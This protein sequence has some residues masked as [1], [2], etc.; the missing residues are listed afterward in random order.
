MHKTKHHLCALSRLLVALMLAAVLSLLGAPRVAAQVVINEVDSD[1]PGTD[2]LEFVELYDGG[3]GNTSLDGLVVVFYN[4]SNDLSYASFDLDGFRTDA[5]GFFLMGNSSVTP[6]PSL[7]FANNFLQNGADAVALY[8]GNAADFPNNTPVT[9]ANL[10][11]AIVYDTSDPDDPGLLVLLNAGQSQVDE[12]GGGNG[13]NHS[14]SRVPNGGIPRNTVTYVQQT[15]TP[16]TSNVPTKVLEIWA[17]QGNGLTSPVATEVVVTTNNVVTV[18]GPDGF[19]MQTPAARSD[20]DAE[21]SDGI[22]VFTGTAP[23]V[24]VGDLVDVSGEI[25]EFFDLTEFSSGPRV[26]IKSS[27]NPLPTAVQFDATTPS[28]H[29]PQPAT[30]L[31]RYEGMLVEVT[32]GTATGPSDQF[33]DVAIVASPARAFREPGIEFPG[34][35]GLPVWDGNPEIFALDP[36]RLGRRDTSI[37]AGAKFSATGALGFAFGEYQLWPA[38]LAL[39]SSPALPRPVRTR[40]SGEVTIATLNMLRFF[41]DVDDPS[42]D[43]PVPSAAEYQGRLRKLS[44]YIRE[45][46]RAPDILAVQEAEN[47]KA[48]QDLAGRIKRDDATL[49]YTVHLLEGNDLGGID[50]G[51]LVR[52]TVPV[53]AVSQLGKTEIFSLDG[54]LLHDRPPLILRATLPDGKAIAVMNLHLRSLSGIDDPADG[55]RVRAKRDEQGKSVSLMVQNLQAANPNLVVAGDLNAFQFTDGYV[56]VLGQIMGTP[57]DASQALL[58]G[59]DNVDPDL[60]NAILMLPVDERYSFIFRGSAQALDHVLISQALQSAVGGIEY[61]RGNADAPASF[62]ADTTT[63]LRSSDHDGL[64]LYLKAGPSGVADD[65]AAPAATR[66]EL[67]PNY[68]N[69]FLSAAQSPGPSGRNSGTTINFAVPQAGKVILRIYS[70]TGQLVRELTNREVGAGRHSAH[71]DGLNQFGHAA[72]SG[73]YF[74][75][76]IAEGKDGGAAFDQTRRMIMMK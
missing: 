14:N 69:P 58:P 52:Q 35:A 25:R 51:F 40:R 27:G 4:G 62:A 59:T 32:E 47:L 73:V 50:V 64:V 68:P 7:T 37:V 15:P 67:A 53:S 46:M 3:A 10:I 31:E 72:A 28:P 6:T 65:G 74:Y 19:F 8:T 41:D 34:L 20:G 12:N 42:L 1:T 21:T 43:E 63:A 13:A 60:I 71:W 61:A 66:Y 5:N 17:I 75:R 49:N 44:T 76:I 57:S 54:S 70:E 55:P 16:G 30:A 36:N 48:L 11:D 45:V 9:T 56:D 2:A 18:V 39:K 29:Q 24:N 22:F 26:T 38:S 33:G 23:G